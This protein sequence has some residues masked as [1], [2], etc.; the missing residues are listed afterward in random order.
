M[1]D[2]AGTV[3]VMKPEPTVADMALLRLDLDADERARLRAILAEEIAHLEECLGRN[4]SE[5]GR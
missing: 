4:G 2:P 3:T 1:G 5:A